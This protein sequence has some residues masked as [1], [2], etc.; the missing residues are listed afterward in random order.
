MTA[1]AWPAEIPINEAEFYVETLTA[2]AGTAFTPHIQT[3]PR[4]GDR[5]AAALH[6]ELTDTRAAHADALIAA[7]HGPAGVILVPER[8]QPDA[9]G[10][11]QSFD[12]Y[13][14]AIGPTDFDDGTAWSDGT[15][16]VEGSGLPR[17]LGGHGHRIVFDGCHPLASGVFATGDS[18]QTGPGSAVLITDAAAVSTDF[19][20]F[21]VYPC[22]PAVREPVTPG[23]AEVGGI[24]VGMRL[25]GDAAVRVRTEPPSWTLYDLHFV[26]AHDA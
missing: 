5:W 25:A 1:R 15:A 20:G 10:S 19:Q 17:V 22:A 12:A 11:L 16:F 7:L 8:R 6:L 4:A 9:H 14:A 23:L 2:Q 3:L 21:A 24:T 13:A 18:V 26:E